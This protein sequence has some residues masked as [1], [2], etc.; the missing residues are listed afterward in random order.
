M[1]GNHLLLWMSARDQGS[2]NQFKSAVEQLHLSEQQLDNVQ[3]D[4]IELGLPNY[5]IL[6]LN[7]ESLAHA[8]FF[9]TENNY[10][11]R[12]VPP[13]L[14]IHGQSTSWLGVLCGARSQSL[15]NQLG[16]SLNAK[17]EIHPINGCP[18]QILISATSQEALLTCAKKL[19]LHTQL[20]APLAM[21]LSVPSVMH[22]SYRKRAALPFGKGWKIERF[23]ATALS[24]E[25]A[26]TNQTQ[27]SKGA[28]FRFS[29]DYQY[30]CYYCRGDQ[31]YEVPVRIGKFLTVARSRRK[32]LKYDKDSQSLLIPASLR[33]PML[34]ERALNLCSGLPPSFDAKTGLLRFQAIPEKV[35]SYV[36]ALLHQETI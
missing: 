23:S 33:P 8:E 29:L 19:G 28:L 5:Q 31:A 12:V 32:V 15:L 18:D 27:S 35:F 10:R 25:D 11:W 16:E 20:D 1:N 30:N 24:W 22:S 2:W 9:P 36:A 13:S 17:V 34:I 26:S 3:N 21:L 7:L 4:D 14:A 6:R